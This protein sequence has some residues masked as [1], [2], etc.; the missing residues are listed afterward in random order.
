MFT[1]GR[2]RGAVAQRPMQFSRYDA[3]SRLK[4]G[5]LTINRDLALSNM[6]TS[7]K[8]SIR[9]AHRQLA[10]NQCTGRWAVS[11]HSILWALSVPSGLQC[12]P[13]MS[14]RPGGAVVKDKPRCPALHHIGQPV[15]RAAL[16]QFPGARQPK[17]RSPG[18]RRPRSQRVYAV[19]NG[20]LDAVA[21]RGHG[22]STD[23]E[24]KRTLSTGAGP[25]V[26]SLERLRGRHGQ[27]QA[28]QRS[29]GGSSSTTYSSARSIHTSISAC[30]NGE[31]A[32]TA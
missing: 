10:A 13:R 24:E 25:I 22:K 28:F 26:D 29:D 32:M 23:T 31:V 12:T 18:L 3:L 14:T 17:P 7:N 16:P 2:R 11:T 8:H 6:Q 20:P 5:R 4:K 21:S 30:A 1:T 19:S 27:G 9:P 15:D